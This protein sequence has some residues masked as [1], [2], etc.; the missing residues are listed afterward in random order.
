MA[1][2]VQLKYDELT[3]VGKQ[4]NTEGDDYAELYSTTRQKVQALYKEWIGLGADKFFD[5][6][7]HDLLP[8]LQR[9]SKA[10]FYSEE[11]LGKIA[12]LIHETDEEN[13]SY[14]KNTLGGGDDFGAA[15]FES[16]LGG[17]GPGGADFGAPGFVRLNF[18]CSRA[19]LEEGLTRLRDA[20]KNVTQ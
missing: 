18:A 17:G 20:T 16:A 13:A 15:G 8:A 3:T 19:T 2:I 10:L 7:E 9:V 4:F 5:E 12:R 11:V 6:M 1:N 14:F